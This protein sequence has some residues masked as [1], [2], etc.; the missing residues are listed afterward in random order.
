MDVFDAIEE[1]RSVRAYKGEPIEK[2]HVEKIVEAARLAPSAN[3]LQ[4]WKLI[5]V[6]DPYVLDDL[7]PVCMSQ[8][9]VGDAGALIVGLVDGSKWSEVDLIIAMDHLCLEAV[10]L[11]YGT[12]WI[13]AFKEE[14]IRRELDVPEDYEPL[15]CMTVGVPDSEGS[16]PTKKSIDELVDW[17][18]VE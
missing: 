11:G 1:R 17:V 7:V 5:V 16:S 4:P 13:G 8:S 6:Q 10:E 9:F 14:G 18:R 15:V 2:E 3:N 12:C